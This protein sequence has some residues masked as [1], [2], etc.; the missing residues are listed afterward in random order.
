M[1]DLHSNVF[2]HP[3]MHSPHSTLIYIIDLKLKQVFE[4]INFRKIKILLYLD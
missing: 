4:T 1:Q 2:I 3:R